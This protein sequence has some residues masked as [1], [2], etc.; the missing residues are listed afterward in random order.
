MAQSIHFARVKYFAEEFTKDCQ[1]DAI[2]KELTKILQEEEKIDET[3]ETKFFEAIE[4]PSL[5]LSAYTPEIAKLL[6]TG[7]E[8]QLHPQSRYYFV[9]ESLWLVLRK[10][11]FTQSK[12][13][14]KE[15][16]FFEL[17]RNV[18]ELENYY[19]KKMLVFDAS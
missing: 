17:A 1:H 4:T 13:I 3:V 9:S 18:T 14:K 11:I 12:A 7:S 16:E 10:E 19:K 8:I 2:L 15:D 5:T 6:K